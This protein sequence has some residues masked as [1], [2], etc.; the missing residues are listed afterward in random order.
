MHGVRCWDHFTSYPD[1]VMNFGTHSCSPDDAFVYSPVLLKLIWP[2]APFLAKINSQPWFV[3]APTRGGGAAHFEKLWFTLSHGS[4][5]HTSAMNRLL[6]KRCSTAL[7]ILSLCPYYKIFWFA[8]IT[9]FLFQSSTHLF[10]PNFVH[11][12]YS[13]QASLTLQFKHIQYSSRSPSQISGL[14]STRRSWWNYS[15]IWTLFYI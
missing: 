3:P 13:Y 14:Y 15:R 6:E 8:L 7:S 12:W 1:R 11:S 4:H 2:A 9:H 5:R 10:I